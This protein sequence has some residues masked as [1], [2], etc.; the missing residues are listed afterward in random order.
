MRGTDFGRL[1]LGIPFWSNR[2]SD[3]IEHSSRLDEKWV[4]SMERSA[5][6]RMTSIAF[7]HDCLQDIIIT[8]LH[9]AAMLCMHISDVNLPLWVSSAKVSTAEVNVL[10]IPLSFCARSASALQG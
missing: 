9:Q 1:N 6:T 4:W 2:F 3:C 8:L 10:E 5:L 7:T